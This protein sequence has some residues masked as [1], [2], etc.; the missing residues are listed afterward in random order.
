[1]KTL[2]PPFCTCTPPERPSGPDKSRPDI[3]LPGPTEPPTTRTSMPAALLSRL[4]GSLTLFAMTCTGSESAETPGLIRSEFIFETAPFP[5]CH[6]STLAETPSGLV[7]AWFGGT[8][9]RHPDV[10]I[11]VSRHVNGRWTE[12]VEVANGVVSPTERHPTW[13]PVL[14]KPREG[15][16][17][18]FY[19]VGPSPST[20][21][22][23]MMTSDD[24]GR[25]WSEP[26][27]LPDGILGPIKNKPV[28]LPNGDLLCG[29]STEGPEGWRV[30]FERTSDLGRTWTRTPPLNDGKT[31]AA[32]QPSILVHDPNRLQ[33]LGR[34]RQGRIFEIWSD[35]GGR[36]WGPMRLTL[37]PNPSSGTDALTLKDGRHLLVYNHAARPRMRTPLNVALSPDGRQWF[38]A[39]VLEHDPA[40][41]AGF[42]YPAVI[43]TSD[44][45]VHITYTWKR[46]RIKHVVLDPQRLRLTPMTET[47]YL[48]PE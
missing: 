11:W 23:M 3:P 8:H 32:I 21:W 17:L 10:G 15:P 26:R 36:T 25:T 33:A 13:N 48:W 16:L 37:L 19:K 12:P 18:L 28:Q 24:D 34:T 40:A 45:L 39:L 9:E 43:Q 41:P 20:W 35:D 22:G 27:P 47:I 1:M 2:T 29:S 30:H 6:A 38:A 31:I 7:A 5:S 42:S 4:L 46:Q 14:F 44:G